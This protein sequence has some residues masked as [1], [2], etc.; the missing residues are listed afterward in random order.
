MVVVLTAAGDALAVDLVDAMVADGIPGVTVILGLMVVD[1]AA[2]VS[3]V[4]VLRL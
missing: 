4:V 3:P 2:A 1:M